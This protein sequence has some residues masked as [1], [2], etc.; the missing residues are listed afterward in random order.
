MEK[1]DITG[2]ATDDNIIGRTGF[3]CWITKATNT[4]SEN[5]ILLAFP[6]QQW[7]YELPPMAFYKYIACLVIY[8][9]L[10]CFF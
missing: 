10:F 7:V 4:H 5:I 2:Q 8:F 1:Y 3:V 9:R 6:Q